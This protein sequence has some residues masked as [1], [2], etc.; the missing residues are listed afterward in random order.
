MFISDSVT[1]WN[2]IIDISNNNGETPLHL[3]CQHVHLFIRKNNLPLLRATDLSP[4][5]FTI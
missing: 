1:F 3:Q 4:H 5:T 2:V